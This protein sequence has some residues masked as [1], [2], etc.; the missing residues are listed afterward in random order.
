MKEKKVFILAIPT[1]IVIIVVIVGIALIFYN[2][3][4]KKMSKDDAYVLASKV[5]V[6]NNISCEVLTETNYGTARVD[7][8]VK[9][10]TVLSVTSGLGGDYTIFDDGNNKV[11]ID[12]EGKEAYVYHD[13]QAEK[14]IFMQELCQVAKLLENNTYQ[15][16][17][18]EFTKMNGL[19]VAHFKLEDQNSTYDVWIDR[20]TGIVQ[21]IDYVNKTQ[22]DEWFKKHYRYS[23]DSVTDDQV[24]KPDI[25]DYEI[26]DL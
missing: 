19:K 18:V 5:A 11:Q 16:T 10:N 6:I 13:Y 25:T 24:K 2:R 20:T 23:V 12:K 14:D 7:Y 1:I 8:K 9:D 3:N 22:E 15:Y 17:F 21:Q 26:I 4:F